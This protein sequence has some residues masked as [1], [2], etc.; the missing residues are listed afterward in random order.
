MREVRHK[1]RVQKLLD[2]LDPVLSSEDSDES[3]VFLCWGKE[4]RCRIIPVRVAD[5]TDEADLLLKLR[6]AWYS[7]RGPWREWLRPLF[8]IDKVEI[9]KVSNRDTG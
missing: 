9:V 8:D 3:V 6:K 4:E 2:L 1:K 7:H 5:Q